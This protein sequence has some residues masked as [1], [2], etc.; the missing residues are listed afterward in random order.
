MAIFTL[1][2]PFARARKS[3]RLGA[4]ALGLGSALLLGGSGLWPSSTQAQQAQPI[5]LEANRLEANSKTGLVTAIGNVRITYPARS[6]QATAAQAQY[7]SRERKMILTGDVYVL[8]QGN[9]LRGE[10]ITYLIDEGRF[11]ATPTS[12]KQVESI[13]LVPDSPTPTG[14]PAPAPL[15]VQSEFG[16]AAT[17]S[18]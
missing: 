5:K 11:V 18:R 15:P 14:T 2:H 8:Q 16:P 9:S 6:I 13:Y 3:T 12:P 10:V 1:P 4:A 17:P 7:F